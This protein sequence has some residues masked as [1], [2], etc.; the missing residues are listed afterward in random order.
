MILITRHG[1]REDFLD[2]NWALTAERPHDP[3]LSPDGIVQARELGVRLMMER[4]NHIFSSP[5]LRT[6]ETAHHIAEELDLPIK[7]E[8]GL[9]E[10]LNPDWFAAMPD[11]L[12][13]DVMARRFPRIDMNYRSAV[14][15]SYPETNES[16]TFKRV[17]TTVERLIDRF[18]DDFLLVAHGASAFGAAK[19]LVP[20]PDGISCA[21]CCLI[22]MVKI[23]GEWVME[24]GGDTSH[25]SEKQGTLRFH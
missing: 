19:A 11:W 7:I 1:N 14:E 21:L 22:K 20:E 3:G 17:A 8:H 13:L 5:F 6:V 15:P 18:D 24:L 16:K 4:V 10:W 2:E 12:P 25:L 9:S 23:N